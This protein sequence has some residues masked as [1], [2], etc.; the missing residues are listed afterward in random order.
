MK[1][2]QEQEKGKISFSLFLLLRLFHTCEPGLESRSANRA[3]VC[4]VE[5]N[6]IDHVANEFAGR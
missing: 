4:P 3:C 6:L 2:A 1:Q 5:L